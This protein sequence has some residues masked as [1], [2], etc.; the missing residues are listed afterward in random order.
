[1]ESSPIRH[2]LDSFHSVLDES[3]IVAIAS[4]YDLYAH[5]GYDEACAILESLAQNATTEQ[6][7]GFNPSGVYRMSEDEHTRGIDMKAP[8][9]QFSQGGNAKQGQESNSKNN[10]GASSRIIANITHPDGESS[11]FDMLES[12]VLQ[13]QNLFPDLQRFDVRHALIEANGV[14]ATA[15]DS[16]LSVQ[17]VQSTSHR[18]TSSEGLLGAGYSWLEVVGKGSGVYGYDM[19]NT[20]YSENNMSDT[21]ALKTPSAVTYIA[22][23][24]NMSAEEVS[25]IYAE[26][27]NSRGATIIGILD[28]FLIQREVASLTSLEKTAVDGLKPKYRNIPEEYLQVIIQITGS[29]STYATELASLVNTHYGKR[30]MNQKLELGYRLTPL[31]HEDIEGLTGVTVD[32]L[33]ERGKKTSSRVPHPG[34]E[35]DTGADLLQT[36]RMSNNLNKK[37]HDAT[38]SAANLYRRGSSNPLYRQ[39]A[40]YYAQQAREHARR[41]QEATSATADLLV[42]QQSSDRM[43][44][45]HGVSIHDGV[46]IA[47]QRALDWWKSLQRSREGHMLNQ[48]LTIITGVGH[49]SA[50]GISPLRKAVAAA[51]T[52][53]GWKLRIETGKFV[54]TGR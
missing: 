47:R 37:K 53:D 39:A 4:D 48:N 32:N 52:R 14:V 9:A 36:R 30:S 38:A 5:T 46:R 23:R 49:H 31:P 45:L 40:G 19:T 29:M 54:I 34:D 43:V 16:L 27:G 33:T 18:M 22:E 17:Y 12:D 24:L 26:N 8:T 44:D 35:S 7:N 21:K 25:I 20:V 28:Q 13:L 42:N 11:K 3:L 10:G 50:G 51:L 2:L 6:A 1:M 41:A 15:L